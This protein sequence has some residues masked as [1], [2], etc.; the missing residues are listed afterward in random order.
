MIIKKGFWQVMIYHLLFSLARQDAT[1]IKKIL[2]TTPQVTKN[3]WTNFFVFHF[4]NVFILKLY[5]IDLFYSL[6]INIS[7]ILDSWNVSMGHIS[8]KSRR[9]HS[10]DGHSGRTARDVETSTFNSS[11]LFIYSHSHQRVHCLILS[12]SY[13]FHLFY[14]K[15]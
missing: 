9:T 2:E 10:W 1:T 13:L 7:Y 15:Y 12:V 3:E 5:A 14:R 11:S 8:S 4:L 6:F